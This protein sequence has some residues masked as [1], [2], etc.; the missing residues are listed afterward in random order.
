MRTQLSSMKTGIAIAM[1]FL[2]GILNA[3]QWDVNGNPGINPANYVGTVDNRPLF[4][5]VNGSSPN[6][7]QALLNEAGSFIVE[8]NNNTNF[9]KAKGSIV[10]GIS[11]ILGGDASSSLVSGWENNLSSA[12]GANIVAGQSNTVLNGAGKSVALGWKNTIRNANQFAIGVGIDLGDFYS[13]GFGID[14]VAT[15]NR[16]FVIGSG[17][18]TA[19]LTNN[20]PLSIMFGL[21]SNSTMLIKDQSVGIRTITPTANFHTVGT[22]RLQGLPTG[23]GRGLVVDNNGNVMVS[24]TALSK[25]ANNDET[26]KQLEDRIK[27]LETTVEELK[28]LLLNKGTA[29][30]NLSSSSDVPVLFQNAPN[31]TKGET[32]IQYYLPKNT[33]SA[34]I[35][36]YS[37]SGQLVRSLSINERGNGAVR[38]SSNDLQSGTYVYKMTADGKLT[39]SKKMIIQD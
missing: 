8:T 4:L 10:N 23:T 14:L 25:T 33:Q 36:I 9:A 38:L 37:I 19:K 5:R 21:S 30:S 20:V 28:Q 3:Q 35:E 15:G 12:G 11:N 1:V 18:G 2:T 24:S 6:P 26:V 13:G 32:S 7:G 29:S 16:S 17:T 34:S 31:P 27:N 22:V 39:D